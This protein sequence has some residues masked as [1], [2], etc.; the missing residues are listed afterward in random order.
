MTN[1]GGLLGVT[2]LL[3]MLLLAVAKQANT[4]SYA[5]APAPLSPQYHPLS[6]K[7]ESPAPDSPKYLSPIYPPEFPPVFS[8]APEVKPSTTPPPPS[9]APIAGDNNA[10]PSYESTAPSPA[11]ETGYPPEQSA[12][13]DSFPPS[14]SLLPPLS[15]TPISGDDKDPSPTAPSPSPALD[16]S[17]QI[18]GRR[19]GGVGFGVVAGM[20][21]VGLGGFVYLKR[22]DDGA[23]RSKYSMYKDLTKKEGI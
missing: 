18:K 3:V 7:S 17:Y 10:G 13:S 23:S 11:I 14:I 19:S 9:M 6:R 16:P 5:P 22:R 21:L 2:M 15:M 8:P 4:M 12:G 1:H 20:C